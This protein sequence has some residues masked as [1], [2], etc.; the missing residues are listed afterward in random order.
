MDIPQSFRKKSIVWQRASRRINQQSTEEIYAHFSTIGSVAH[1][2]FPAPVMTHI[3]PTGMRK[4]KGRR[5]KS[6]PISL[7]V[8]NLQRGTTDAAIPGG[9]RRVHRL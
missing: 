8:Q 7:K 5:Q 9:D 6:R 4:K 2:G 3:R 1:A